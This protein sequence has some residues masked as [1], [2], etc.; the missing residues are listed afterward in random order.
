MPRKRKELPDL[1]PRGYTF[2]EG[3]DEDGRSHSPPTDEAIHALAER[4]HFPP[5]FDLAGRLRHQWEWWRADMQIGPDPT[6]QERR[7]FLHELAERAERLNDALSKAGTVERGLILDLY[8]PG[9]LKLDEL[10]AGAHHLATAAR[11]A[12]R[13]VTPS[14]RG[15]R[16]RVETV[17]LLCKLWRTYRAAFGTDAPKL[18]RVGTVYGGAF[19]DFAGDTLRLFGVR[20]SNASLGKAIQKAQTAVSNES[21]AI[22]GHRSYARN[23]LLKRSNSGHSKR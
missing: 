2:P 21:R 18:S 7:A 10:R 16:G 17:E 23:C 8:P 4:Y 20:M 5:D 19:F 11:V 3:P 13:R 15:A 22:G 1:R 12:E 9:T 6:A 14:R